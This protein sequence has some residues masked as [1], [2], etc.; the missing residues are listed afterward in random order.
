[1]HSTI[2]APLASAKVGSPVAHVEAGLRGFDRSM[3]EE[4]NR[5]LTDALADHLFVTEEDAFG[6]LSKEGR[7]RDRIHLVGNVMIDALRHFLRLAQ[8]S[9][10]G[11]ELRFLDGTGFVP[12]AVLTL[13]RPSNVD[14]IDKFEKLMS[15]IILWLL[16]LRS[17]GRL[18]G[19]FPGAP[20]HAGSFE[21]CRVKAPPAPV[22]DS[23]IRVFGFSLLAR[24]ITP[25]ADRFRRHIGRDDGARCALPNLTLLENTERPVTLIEG[26]NQAV[27]QDPGRIVSAARDILTVESTRG[28]EPASLVWD[29]HAAERIVEILRF[30]DFS[31]GTTR[32]TNHFCGWGDCAC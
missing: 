10:I 19:Y 7:P 24:P 17:G 20:A 15:A 18:A 27:G 26:T 4:I 11:R 8:K 1:V 22:A 32:N 13:H 3:S 6:N 29:G 5:I 21:R 14:S 25:R 12:F 16:C 30:F 28:Q 2:A 23:T 31:T 9:N